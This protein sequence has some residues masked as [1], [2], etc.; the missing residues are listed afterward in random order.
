MDSEL[1]EIRKV[2]DLTEKEL[3]AFTKNIQE[4]GNRTATI[5]SQLLEA[6]AVFARSGFT[7]EQISMLTEEAAVLKNVS[8]GIEDMSQSAQVLIS[9]MK[10]Y[11]IPAERVRTITDQLNIISN[12]AAISFDDLAEGMSR[13]GAVFASQD[14]SIGQLGALLT[15]ANEIL[16]DISKTSNGLKTI[17][18]RLRTIKGDSAKYQELISGITEKYGKAVN[19]TDTVTGQ[20]R[21]TYDI[22][23]DLA[24]V[25]DKLSKNEQQV[26][27]EQLAGKNQITVL[28]ALLSNWE[29]VEK[30]IRNVDNAAG[31]AAREQNAYLNS[32]TGSI[33]RL[34]ASIENMYADVQASPLLTFF[35][36]LAT[37]VVQLT[38]KIG[39]IPIALGAASG[40]S[41]GFINRINMGLSSI[42][43]VLGGTGGGLIGSFKN[44]FDILTG[45]SLNGVKE[46]LRDIGNLTA[47]E[48]KTLVNILKYD[49][50]RNV[51]LAQRTALS[52]LQQKATEEELRLIGKQ[53][54]MEQ[55]LNTVRMIGIG[56]IVTAGVAIVSHI[57]K[58]WNKANESI[59]KVYNESSEKIAEIKEKIKSIN[60]DIEAVG[61][62]KTSAQVQQLE[63]L[64]LELQRTSVLAQKAKED[65]IALVESKFSGT[66]G[67]RLT[68]K[69]ETTGLDVDFKL[70]DV[71]NFFDDVNEKFIVTK[72]TY[73]DALKII[74]GQT[75]SFFD[76][77][78]ESTDE[79]V[80]QAI[81][82]LDKLKQALEEYES[83]QNLKITFGITKD[84]V[85]T[86]L[87]KTFND[88][89]DD[90]SGDIDWE[91]MSSKIDAK[92][93]SDMVEY[94]GQPLETF[95]RR[96]Y[97]INADNIDL[98]QKQ[99]SEVYAVERELK[100]YIDLYDM[101]TGDV[102]SKQ[103]VKNILNNWEAYVDVLTVENGELKISKELVLQKAQAQIEA[104]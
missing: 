11:D 59:V 1:V 70:G 100:D 60:E 88:A 52:G 84:T 7:T 50:E 34:K 74:E 102:S 73:A 26:I 27:G 94:F 35:V 41:M 57:I 71:L 95:A 72:D 96:M 83:Q 5:T 89:I 17:S 56:L 101:A 51:R 13:V 38:D 2:T 39:I 22:L 78:R 67:E 20:L 40:A 43:N 104:I 79:Y 98:W 31:S 45:K 15:G 4:I 75:Y 33:D 8:D 68:F 28:Q 32:L 12:N 42:V 46:S 29:G 65:Y 86:Y 54:T 58:N 36:D 44:L 53:V 61:G 91:K 24:D 62:R 64:N 97:Q 77:I 66:A 90:A 21:G 81:D 80:I 47:E 69:D 25:W 14:T 23:K 63:A 99:Y 18:Q 30:A 103:L 6:S 49:S 37:A 9:V 85:E 19:I 92:S 10:A 48:K 93:V 55:L 76:G 82:Y 3:T 16:Q 87:A